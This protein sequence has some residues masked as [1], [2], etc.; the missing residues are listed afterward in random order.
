MIL[1]RHPCFALAALL[2]V[3]C[4]CA[5]QAP[6]VAAGPPPPPPPTVVQSSPPLPP[7]KAARRPAA[8]VR[9][10][11]AMPSFPWPPP[12]SSSRLVLLNSL[13]VS[14]QQNPNLGNIDDRITAALLS[15]GYSERAYF[16]VP[17]GFA[18]VTKLEQIN[19]D[20][21]SKQPPARW[22]ATDDSGPSSFSLSSYIRAL[23]TANAGYYRV[24]AFLVTD[25]PFAAT[26]AAPTEDQT[27][28][29]L[30][31]GFNGLPA[32]VRPKPYGA[33]FSCTALIYEFMRTESSPPTLTSNGPDAETHL[34]KAGIWD[35][36]KG[37]Q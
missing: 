36:L 35:K 15:A 16:A 5:K 34:Q 37:G 11:P 14:G 9:P 17:D 19:N 21:T 13:L 10:V 8:A 12:Q 27:S 2:V 28:S 20:G 7:P 1:M 32:D 3:S 30:R 25:V 4:G 29:W 26:G 31:N 23:F 33:G 18:V 22:V 6:I 24:I